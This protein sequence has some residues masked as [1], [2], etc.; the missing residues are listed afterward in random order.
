MFTLQLS[1]LHDYKSPAVGLATHWE[2]QRR[3]SPLLEKTLKE[4]VEGDRAL[5]LDQMTVECAK[6]GIK[7]S[8]STTY[9]TLLGMGVAW[10]KVISQSWCGPDGEE[11]W[12]TRRLNYVHAH[13]NEDP[14]CLGFLDECIVKALNSC[15]YEWRHYS[16]KKPRRS[17][18]RWAA[19]CHVLGAIGYGGF[20]VI[21]NVA[22][23]VGQ[24]KGM[25]AKG[26]V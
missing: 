21:V 11:K 22:D 19:Q 17:A 4:L 9:R 16:D 8:K 20:K 24:G 5:T 3:E 7:S 14:R 10:R 6:V 15:Q 13:L 26:Y 12:A 25:T 2:I 18:P 1:S 23:F